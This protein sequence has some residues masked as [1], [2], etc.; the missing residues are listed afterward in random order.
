M[1]GKLR[2]V[3]L[4][5]ASRHVQFT[6][7]VPIEK[8]LPEPGEH[9]TAGEGVTLSDALT[10]NVT[11]TPARLTAVLVIELGTV[12]TGGATSAKLAVTVVFVVR[13]TTQLPVPEQPPLQ[14]LKLEPE[15]AVAVRVIVVPL[16]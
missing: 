9:V 3:V 13:F 16:L 14:P 6:V 2:L 1:T 7:V 15:S 12:R 4:P 5:A 10:L 8:R 11:V